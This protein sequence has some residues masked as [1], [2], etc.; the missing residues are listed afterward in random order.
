MKKTMLVILAT[1][2]LAACNS[3]DSILSF[4]EIETVPDNLNQLIDPH[5]PLQLVYEGEQIAYVVYQSAGDLITEVEEQGDTLNILL[6]KADGS[7]IPTEQ[8]VYK[9]TLDDHH[10]VIEVFVNGKSIPFDRVSTIGEES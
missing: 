9:L 4:S 1:V 8:H 2:L 3:D 7:T 5:E 6:T 10:E